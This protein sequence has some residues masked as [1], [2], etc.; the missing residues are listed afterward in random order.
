MVNHSTDSIIYVLHQHAPLVVRRKTKI[1]RPSPW[2]AKELVDSV[3]ERNR[4]HHC[5]MLHRM[6]DVPRQEHINGQARAKRMDRWL[7]NAYFLFQCNTSDHQKLWRVMKSI[8]ICLTH[9][10][11]LL[12]S[13]I[14]F[15]SI[16]VHRSCAEAETS[17]VG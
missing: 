11:L 4:L 7:R 15:L 5:L 6:N 3:M 8:L 10:L 12:P 2:L 14:S 16:L 9:P 17:K 1:C 13:L